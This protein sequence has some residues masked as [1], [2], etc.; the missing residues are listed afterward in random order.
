M[1]VSTSYTTI[2]NNTLLNNVGN[3]IVLKNAKH[4]DIYYT[5]S[6]GNGMYG[7]YL[8]TCV[9]TL[10]SGTHVTRSADNGVVITLCTNLTMTNILVK[11]SLNYGTYI[12]DVAGIM[13]SVHVYV[14][15]NTYGMACDYADM[16]VENVSAEYN[17]NIGRNCKI[18]MV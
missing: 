10:I 2:I 6:D 12:R 1:L 9:Y 7:F 15:N 17:H 18:R 16:Y 5:L 14:S 11:Q 3:G 8:D 4:S 13:E